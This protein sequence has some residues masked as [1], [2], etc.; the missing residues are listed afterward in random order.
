M[1]EGREPS[2]LYNY[3]FHSCHPVS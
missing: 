3:L 1:I 2:W